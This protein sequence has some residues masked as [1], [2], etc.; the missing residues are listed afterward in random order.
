MVLIGIENKVV[1]LCV[2]IDQSQLELAREMYPDWILQEQIGNE[3][4]G[5]ILNNDG[6]F[7]AP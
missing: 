3:N 1:V 7:T 6:T 4:I 5:W 2:S